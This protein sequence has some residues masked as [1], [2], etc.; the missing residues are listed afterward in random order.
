MDNVDERVM[1]AKSDNLEILIKDE[2][3]E[4]IKELFDSL[5]NRYQN[6]LQSV[7]GSEFVFNYV[8]LLYH[9]CHKINPNRGG[10]YIDSPDWIKNRK[11][12]INPINKKDK[13]FFNAL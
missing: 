12:T 13:I 6:S 11:A 5:K 7:K 4:A 8:H 2:A 10:S 9:K 1:H 3:D